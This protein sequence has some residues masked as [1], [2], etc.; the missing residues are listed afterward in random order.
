MSPRG[1]DR[2]VG[3]LIWATSQLATADPRGGERP[4]RPRSAPNPGRRASA[5]SARD[6]HAA[7]PHAPTSS[8]ASNKPPSTRAFLGRSLARDVD[9]S[10]STLLGDGSGTDV[11]TAVRGGG[12]R[13]DG[14]SGRGLRRRAGGAVDARTA[15]RRWLRRVRELNAVSA[16]APAGCPGFATRARGRAD[17]KIDTQADTE[18]GVAAR[19][20][21]C[22][23]VLAAE[24]RATKPQAP[25]PFHL[26][27]GS[28]T[29]QQTPIGTGTWCAPVPSEF[30]ISS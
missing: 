25:G 14:R 21:G 24:E 19:G 2:R 13:H 4:R 23:T 17:G 20:E 7:M 16:S 6:V 8:A 27:N 10:S 1:A 26:G 5:P 29:G 22:G 12:Q 28:Q 11:G 15:L 18:T 30:M 9:L 3:Q